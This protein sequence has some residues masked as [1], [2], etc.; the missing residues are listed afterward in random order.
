MKNQVIRV[1]RERS[2]EA[3]TASKKSRR[4]VEMEIEIEI[5]ER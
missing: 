5:S 4:D 2:P 1:K 3:E